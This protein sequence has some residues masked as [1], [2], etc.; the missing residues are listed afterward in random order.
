MNQ[1]RF[2]YMKAC[3]LPYW[4]RFRGCVILSCVRFFLIFSLNYQQGVTRCCIRIDKW[5]E[6]RYKINQVYTQI[7]SKLM[8]TFGSGKSSPFERVDFS[9]L[10]H[11]LSSYSKS[12]LN[13]LTL[14]S[15]SSSSEGGFGLTRIMIALFFACQ[16][17]LH[18]R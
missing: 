7:N 16:I 15:L 10:Y 4:S 3:Q 14:V 11:F 2:Y 18:V 6:I 17:Y 9:L 12:E 5:E 1:N 13:I 8:D